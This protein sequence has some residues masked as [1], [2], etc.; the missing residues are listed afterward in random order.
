[1][2]QIMPSTRTNMQMYRNPG[3]K[4]YQYRNR[5]HFRYFFD[6]NISKSIQTYIYMLVLLLSK[7][8]Y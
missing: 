3:F 6:N 2:K 4:H 8:L 7:L 1:M 5:I